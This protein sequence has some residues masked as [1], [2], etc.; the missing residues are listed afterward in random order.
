MITFI[1]SKNL[2]YELSRLCKSSEMVL[3][4]GKRL[5]I[6]VEQKND[7]ILLLENLKILFEILE[8]LERILT[9]EQDEKILNYETNYHCLKCQQKLDIKG[10]TCYNCGSPIPRCIICWKDPEPSDQIV[11]LECCRFYAHKNHLDEW[12][13]K[14]DKCPI[15][16]IN[17][18]DAKLVSLAKLLSL[19]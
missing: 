2:F 5:S 13:E 19:A 14:H 1:E 7:P 8:T 3:F 6:A 18:P 15:C 12:L 9:N 4:S 11:I 10:E 16:N 17:H